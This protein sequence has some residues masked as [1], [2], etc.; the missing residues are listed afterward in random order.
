[1]K[2]RLKFE[3]ALLQLDRG[4]EGDG[5]TSLREAIASA[6]AE[7]DDITLVRSLVCLGEFLSSTNQFE[8]SNLLNRAIQI[9]IEPDLLSWEKARAIEILRL[10]K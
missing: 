1:M 2:A 6:E 4:R 9:E 7:D 10:L 3:K 5:V 8:A